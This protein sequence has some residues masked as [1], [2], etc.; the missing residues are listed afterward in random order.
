MRSLGI[1]SFS[2][3]MR[4]LHTDCI[5]DTAALFPDLRFGPV[6]RSLQR[7][8]DPRQRPASPTWSCAPASARE[9]PGGS[10]LKAPPGSDIAFHN[11][12]SLKQRLF[13][14][15]HNCSLP[16]GSGRNVYLWVWSCFHGF[17]VRGFS[18]LERWSVSV[19]S[20]NL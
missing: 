14:L 6:L 17:T 10:M 3:S 20:L 18:P 9:E 13:I 19:E 7:M 1:S 16:G 4:V 12:S 11:Y 5:L 2:F 15:V 8:V